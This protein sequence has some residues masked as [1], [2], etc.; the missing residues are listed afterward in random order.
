MC[1]IILA[2]NTKNKVKT[3]EDKKKKKSEPLENVNEWVVNQF[4]DQRARGIEGFGA[5]FIDKDNFVDLKRSTGEIKFL[6]DLYKNEASTV[7][8]HHR[9]PTSSDNKI[10]QTH[11]IYVDN[12][13]MLNYRYLVIH[14]GMVTNCNDLKEKHE[15]LG[16]KYTTEYTKTFGNTNYSDK[17]FNDTESLAIELALFIEGKSQAIGTENGMAFIVVQMEKLIDKAVKIF[18]GRKHGMLHM[19][20]TTGQIR[21]S[22][23]GM[24]DE[25]KD[26]I[27]YS[28]DMND[29]DMKLKSKQIRTEK[30]E[31]PKQL[32]APS[33]EAFT[34]PLAKFS[35][36][37]LAGRKDKEG[38]THSPYCECAACKEFRIE[39]EKVAKAIEDKET[40]NMGPDDDE[41]PIF[42]KDGITHK[43]TCGCAKCWAH[44]G[45]KVMT[46]NNITRTSTV[47]TDGS[48]SEEYDEKYIDDQTTAFKELIAENS[49]NRLTAEEIK[50]KTDESLENYTD[51]IS[52]LIFEFKD[53]VLRGEIDANKDDYLIQCRIFMETM[54]KVAE[55]GGTRYQE[56]KINE[57]ADLEY[58][59]SDQAAGWEV[60]RGAEDYGG[61]HDDDDESLGT[62]DRWLKNH[63]ERMGFHTQGDRRDYLSG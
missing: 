20:K 62:R 52:D 56:E 19:A 47:N 22:S 59:V 42:E 39:E 55:I 9:T 31:K 21:I 33:K 37:Q 25:T 49:S 40:I 53:R 26:E 48:I 4:Q 46:Q 27:M 57:A 35:D 8:A 51:K 3:G 1:G 24:G 38:V 34:H 17:K 58:D 60:S 36:S 44:P 15:K 18:Y 43:M 11:P 6:L 30:Y 32:E 23:E 54:E 29:E 50:D 10:S 5:I 45:S 2:R 41:E 28:F 12:S 16:F 7:I 61:P 14:N 63:R 13:K